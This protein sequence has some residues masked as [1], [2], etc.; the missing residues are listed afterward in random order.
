MEQCWKLRTVVDSKGKTRKRRG[1][2][3]QGPKLVEEYLR[4]KVMRGQKEGFN[5]QRTRT[6]VYIN[7]YKKSSTTH[8]MPFRFWGVI[9]Q[10][11]FLRELPKGVPVEVYK[12]RSEDGFG[13]TINS[14]RDSSVLSS[15]TVIYLEVVERPRGTFLTRTRGLSGLVNDRIHKRQYKRRNK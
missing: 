1:S 8:G 15:W 14:T 12:I 2:I 9:F 13:Y 11:L 10:E 6:C 7:V 5:N 4:R 3:C